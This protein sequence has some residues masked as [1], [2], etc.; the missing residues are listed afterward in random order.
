MI[1]HDLRVII[2][3]IVVVIDCARRL[4][5]TFAV[6]GD[7]RNTEELH[8]GPNMES[9]T[10]ADVGSALK[11]MKSNKAA[12]REG[13]VVE[14]FKHAGEPVWVF[15]A[16]HFTK[17]LQ[18]DG[19]PEDWRETEFRMLLKKTKKPSKLEEFR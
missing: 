15:L 9:V 18:G 19:F 11:R 12:D 5:G 1:Y 6:S 3:L 13:I 16:S 14:M 8:G 17:I 10:A 4:A 7:R 2:V